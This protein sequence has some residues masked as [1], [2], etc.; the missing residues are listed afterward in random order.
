MRSWRDRIFPRGLFF[1]V[2]VELLVEMVVQGVAALG[3]RRRVARG[4]GSFAPAEVR[5]RGVVHHLQGQSVLM[6]SPPWLTFALLGMS[7]YAAL[8]LLVK[9]ETVEGTLSLFLPEL[10][11]AGELFLMCLASK[12]PFR[13]TLAFIYLPFA[14]F[15][16]IQALK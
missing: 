4:P 5:E 2:C 7:L 15:Y 16:R 1:D 14:N 6:S 13:V 11:A 10:H 12:T 8:F 9:L 3:P